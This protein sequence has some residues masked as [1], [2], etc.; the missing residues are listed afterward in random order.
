MLSLVPVGSPTQ[1]SAQ[2]ELD[3]LISLITL[4]SDP[5][6]ARERVTA[7]S[8]AAAAAREASAQAAQDRADVVAFRQQV[9]DEIA[10]LRSRRKKPSRRNAPPTSRSARNVQPS[11]TRGSSKSSKWTPDRSEGI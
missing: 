5:A 2:A 4:L 8:E 7:L 10:A 11:S 1:P 9:E 3:V 6:A